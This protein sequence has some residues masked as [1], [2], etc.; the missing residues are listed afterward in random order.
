MF[1][2]LVYLFVVCLIDFQSDC[3]NFEKCE[4]KNLVLNKYGVS[5]LNTD[6]LICAASHRSSLRTNFE[7]DQGDIKYF[8]IFAIGMW[9]CGMNE[10][11]NQCQVKC[12]SLLDDDI[13]D[14]VYCASII[15]SEIGV[16]GWGLSGGNC[17]DVIEELDRCPVDKTPDVFFEASKRTIFKT[18]LIETKCKRR[19]EL[20]QTS[21]PVELKLFD[22]WCR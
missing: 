19:P 12:S 2:V 21:A 1:R 5:K 3:K 8:G 7:D 22:R 11:G 16:K 4:M 10:A 14:D 13:M 6:L 20:P 15:L 18:I 17:A 9:W